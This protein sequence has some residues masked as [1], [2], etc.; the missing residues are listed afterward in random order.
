MRIPSGRL[1]ASA[2]A[3]ALTIAGVAFAQNDP[4]VGTWKLNTTKSKYEPGPMPKSNTITITA[5]GN[6]IHVVAKGEDAAG[7]PTGIDYTATYDGK[8][9]AVKGA[10]AYDTVSLKR[11]DPNT[12][13]QIR[14]KEGKTVQTMTRKVSADG[15][16]MTVTTRGKDENGR[17]IN[18]VAVY[19]RQ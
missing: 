5:A 1:V 9:S 13:E 8:D 6:G 4:V 16:T 11:V 2:T 15:K 12:S 19:D 3:I 18:T 7:K 17:T 10:P 14:K